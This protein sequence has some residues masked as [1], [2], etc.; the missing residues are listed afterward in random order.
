MPVYPDKLLT[1]PIDCTF[2]YDQLSD[3]YE[4]VRKSDGFVVQLDK[5]FNRRWDWF[6]GTAEASGKVK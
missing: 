2:R 5:R 1:M 3:R 6:A 4:L